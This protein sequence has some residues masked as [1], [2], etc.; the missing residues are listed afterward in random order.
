MMRTIDAPD[1]YDERELIADDL[2]HGHGAL[3]IMNAISTTDLADARQRIIDAPA[4]RDGQRLRVWRVLALGE[5]FE[6]LVQLDP[7]LT[8]VDIVLG[9]Q[10]IIGS[11]GANRVLPG[12]RGQG[13]HIDYPYWDIYNPSAYPRGF[14]AAYALNLQVTILLD[15]F[16]ESSG[17][18]AYVPG[19]QTL[20]RFPTSR[21]EF[22]V[23][24]QRMLGRAGDVVVFNGACWH[25]A[26]DNDSE[27]ERTGL[28]LQYLPKF[29]K[30]MER[31]L[32]TVPA[33]AMA[34]ATPTMRRLLGLHGRTVDTADLPDDCA[35][36]P[37]VPR[38]GAA[39]TDA[40][41]SSGN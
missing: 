37:E 41:H 29:V 39:R 31:L 26:M 1:V 16:T 15:D 32:E 22:D 30:P 12:G 8:V 40:G 19:T 27:D 11:V 33:E 38:S 34:R 18:T 9:D 6:R 35:E 3:R 20:L 24:A 23:G 13:A 17:A 14:S 10:A 21:Q 2:L 25:C 5:V 36:V 7:V 4:D 28:L